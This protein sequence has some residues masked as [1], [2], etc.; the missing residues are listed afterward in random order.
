LISSSDAANLDLKMPFLPNTM[1]FKDAQTK[2]WTAHT[3]PTKL[4][5]GEKL[6]MLKKI[7]QDQENTGLHFEGRRS[8]AEVDLMTQHLTQTSQASQRQ[9]LFSS[10]SSYL[11]L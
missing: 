7:A 4:S 2:Y 3:P 11:L 1:E 8:A 6:S 5:K 9:N 10:F